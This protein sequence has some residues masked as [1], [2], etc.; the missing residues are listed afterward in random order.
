MRKACSSITILTL[1]G[2]MSA[3]AL[4]AEETKQGPASE[5]TRSVGQVIDDSTITAKV[6]AAL[7]ADEQVKGTQINVST[8]NGLV[9]LTGDVRDQDQVW[10]AGKVAHGVEGVK[11]V[12]N[13]LT[14]RVASAGE[15]PG[16]G[17][18]PGT[19]ALAAFKK[20]DS[21]QDEQVTRDEVNPTN[22]R[23]TEAFNQADGNQDGKLDQAEFISFYTRFDVQTRAGMTVGEGTGQQART[24]EPTQ[25]LGR[26]KGAPDTSA[27][28]SGVDPGTG[29]IATG[30]A[31]R[32]AQEQRRNL[33]DRTA[34]QFFE[35]AWITTKT[36]SALLVDDQVKG[37][38]I[39]V[40]THQS[41]VTLHGRVDNQEQAAQAQKLAAGIDGVKS[42]DNKL[43]VAT[44]A[45]GEVKTESRRE[46]GAA[47]RAGEA[48]SDAT[49]TAKVKTALLA[50][51]DVKGLQ[52]NVDTSD[53]VVTLKGSVESQAQA[54]KAKQLAQG[55]EGVKSVD[56]Q[57]TVKK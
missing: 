26:D 56:S 5:Q 10:R 18:A 16:Q 25:D 20:F 34:A 43:V 41:A 51:A 46:T 13:R 8:S 17:Q 23:S 31:E 6:K 1:A 2:L 40:D 45:Q 28:R 47:G 14:A 27:G 53:G 52:I 33:S 54:A 38:H 39:N 7:L 48:V 36:K 37:I 24:L 30:E 4:A 42:V 15:Q 29:R 3:N 32:P 57:L 49:V 21:N 35:D 22:A 9:T 55:I 50:D 19:G 11:S 12:V 44:A